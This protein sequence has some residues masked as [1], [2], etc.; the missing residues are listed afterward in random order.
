MST[1]DKNRA[2]HGWRR[3]A[4]RWLMKRGNPILN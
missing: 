4:F 1:M 2:R 3:Q